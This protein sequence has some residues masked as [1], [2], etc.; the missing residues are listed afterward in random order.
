MIWVSIDELKRQEQGHETNG[1]S[2]I[3]LTWRQRSATLVWRTLQKK[4]NVQDSDQDIGDS[5]SCQFQDQVR[6]EMLTE[7][8]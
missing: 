5:G 4:K 7:S 6:G 8:E 3:L 2:L 1:N